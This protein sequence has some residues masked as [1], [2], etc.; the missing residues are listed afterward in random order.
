MESKYRAYS[1][2][3]RHEFVKQ[4]AREYYAREL[5]P[6]PPLDRAFME[7]ENPGKRYYRKRRTAA[8][9]VLILAVLS[10]MAL[11]ASLLSDPTYSEKGLLHRIYQLKNGNLATDPQDDS[12]RREETSGITIHTMDDIDDA[13]KTANGQLYVPRYIS[14]GYELETLTVELEFDG[15]ITADYCFQKGDEKLYITEMYTDGEGEVTSSGGKDSKLIRTEDRVVYIHE[16][17]PDG[18]YA[19]VITEDAILGIC[20]TLTK[21]ETIRIARNLMREE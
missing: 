18:Q 20:S 11:K 21:K 15:M 5:G 3:E 14:E 1:Q 16:K 19:T 12:L 13:V 9:A 7:K 10:G 4:A 6:P 2:E 17:S 8:A